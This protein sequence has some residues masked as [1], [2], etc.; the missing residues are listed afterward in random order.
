[1]KV[2]GEEREPNVVSPMQALQQNCARTSLV[3]G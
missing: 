2:N 3:E 1:L